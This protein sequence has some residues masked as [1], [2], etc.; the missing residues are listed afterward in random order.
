MSTAIEEAW[1]PEPELHLPPPR[2]LQPSPFPDLN[3]PNVAAFNIAGIAGL[4]LGAVLLV[5]GLL[6]GPNVLL[7]ILGI[8]LAAAGA[9]ALT[10]PK[11]KA[12]AARAR[13]ERLVREGT[14]VMARIVTSTNLTGD[15]LYGRSVA[16]MITLPGG[17]LVRREANADER[18]L[19]KR[20]PAN[21]TALIDM[22]TSDVELYCALPLRAVAPPQAA[23][24]QANAPAADPFADLPMAPAAA[25]PLAAGGPA[26]VPPTQTPTPPAPPPPAQQQQTS[27]Y[28]GLPWE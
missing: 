7:L 3:A 9:A 19:P 28:Q 6:G 14:P 8:A 22:Q 17:D 26:P 13:S 1:S 2:R 5:L 11:R 10:L 24:Q 20:I 23:G 12:E 15:S 16:Y 25:A 4:V 18:A 27:G 21:V